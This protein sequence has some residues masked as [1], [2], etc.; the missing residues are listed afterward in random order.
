MRYSREETKAVAIIETSDSSA[1][2]KAFVCKAI[3]PD[4]LR[5]TSRIEIPNYST[6]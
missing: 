4:I 5:R 2:P 1:Y 6:L 3:H